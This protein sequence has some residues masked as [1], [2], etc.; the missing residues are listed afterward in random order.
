MINYSSE[1]K[2]LPTLYSRDHYLLTYNEAKP[3][4]CYILNYRMLSVN[5]VCLYT[6]HAYDYPHYR[7]REGNSTVRTIH[8]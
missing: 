4:C 5:E 3:P 6:I 1:R 7:D 2:Y 8:I